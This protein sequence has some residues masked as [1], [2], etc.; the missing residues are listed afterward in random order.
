M[1]WELQLISLYVFICKHYRATLAN[2]CER[3]A[4]YADLQFSDEEA[5]TL[6]LYG[7]MQGYHTLKAIHCYARKHLMD[8]FPQLP[9]YVAFDQRINH[10]HDV[11]VPLVDLLSQELTSTLNMR[12]WVGLTDSMPIVM[13]QQGRRFRAKVA[14]ELATN[15]GYCPAKKLHYYGVKLHVVA[16]M[17]PGML[18]LPTCVGLTGA[19]MNDRKAFEQILPY[20]PE[21]MF[22]CFADK[23]YQ[24]ENQAVRYEYHTTLYTPVKREKGQSSLDAADQLLSTAISRVRQPIEAFFNWIQEK[25]EYKW[26]AKYVPTKA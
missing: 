15:N 21:N 16:C 14:P 19:G 9:G 12:F 24:L 23:A 8:W 17:R 11:F 7:I 26:Q 1:D 13:A 25:K 6:Y 4:P 2:Y 22:D 5:I 10:L 20:L 18:P 3:L